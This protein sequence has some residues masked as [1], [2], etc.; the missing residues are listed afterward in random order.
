MKLTKLEKQMSKSLRK[1]GYKIVKGKDWIEAHYEPKR[2]G[3]K[4]NAR[5]VA[6]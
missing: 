5:N 3:K 1:I 4:V 6:G 2:L